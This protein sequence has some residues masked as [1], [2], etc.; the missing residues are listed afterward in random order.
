MQYL[1]RHLTRFVYTSP[2][3]ESV[4]ELR[5]QPLELDRQ[6]CLRF[7]VSR[8]R[9]ARKRLRLSRSLRQ[10]RA[11]LRHSR[12]IT[13]GSTSRSNPPWTSA[14]APDLPGRAAGRRVGRGRRDRGSR[15]E[16]RRLAA[17]EPVRAR[18]LRRSQQ[19]ARG[20]RLQPRAGS[21]DDAARAQRDALRRSSRTSRGR[22]AWIRRSTTRCARAPACARTSRTS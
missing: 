15:G 7:N 4:M 19:F 8:R 9:S 17:A 13:R 5:M 14:D 16:H 3:C 21:A 18:R 6:Q 12:R 11:L 1:V 22:R 20:H 10:R 2:V